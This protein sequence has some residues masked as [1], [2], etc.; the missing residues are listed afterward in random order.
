MDLWRFVSH[1]IRPGR[2]TNS[3]DETGK[4][5]RLQVT[6]NSFENRT[7]NHMQMVG[8]ASAI[9]VG[10]DVMCINVGAD[11]SN[12]VIIASNNQKFRPQNLKA[13]EVLM[14]SCTNPQQSIYLKADGTIV[15]TSTNEVVVN[16]KKVTINGDLHVTGAITAGYGSSD[17]VGL[18]S[19]K[20]SGQDSHNDAFTTNSPTAGT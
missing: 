20:H 18:Q 2:T 4:I 17:Q 12:G 13:G 3:P 16:A 5:G 6:H 19:H 8:F 7:L 15:V 14:Y 10:T 9:P 1:L 11:N